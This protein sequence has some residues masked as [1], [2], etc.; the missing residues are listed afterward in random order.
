MQPIV[1]ALHTTCI[2]ATLM[3]PI[4]PSYLPSL[5]AGPSLLHA[6]LL[7]SEAVCSGAGGL[8]RLLRLLRR[9]R[10]VL[11]LVVVPPLPPLLCLALWLRP[12]PFPALNVP[13][14]PATPAQGPKKLYPAVTGFQVLSEVGECPQHCA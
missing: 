10:R 12:F 8:L 14:S 2:P 6:V 4:L 1:R 13:P 7:H 9:R 11:L 5:P 3:P